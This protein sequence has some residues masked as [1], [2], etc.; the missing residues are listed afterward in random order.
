MYPILNI[1]TSN[2]NFIPRN[3][4][5][6]FPVDFLVDHVRIYQDSSKTSQTLGCDPEDYPTS[7]Y[8]KQNAH[9]FE[10]PVC[11]NNVCETGECESCPDD[12]LET[13][14]CQRKTQ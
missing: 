3:P 13:I 12:C 7:E 8:I 2:G 9:L 6:Q 5:L 4:D 1:A 10:L 11:G 14:Y